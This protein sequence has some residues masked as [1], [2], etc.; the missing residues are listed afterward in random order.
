MAPERNLMVC[1]E[2]VENSML[3][4]NP[5]DLFLTIGSVRQILAPILRTTSVDVALED[6]EWVRR[7]LC[8]RERW[9]A[10]TDC[11]TYRNMV[12][13]DTAVAAIIGSLLDPPLDCSI[14]CVG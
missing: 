3:A 5:G 9:V 14:R 4:E 12:S 6:E 2:E 10:V 7:V 13:R 8:G 1:L 11:D